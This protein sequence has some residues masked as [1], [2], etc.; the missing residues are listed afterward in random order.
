[1]FLIALLLDLYSIVVL[2][3]VVLSWV[4]LSEDNPLVRLTTA[5]TEPVLRPL[6]NLLPAVGGFDFSPMLLLLALR[7][8][9]QLMLD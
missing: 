3:Y 8:L 2:A 9:R 7:L 4:Q 6:R 5:L 1:M